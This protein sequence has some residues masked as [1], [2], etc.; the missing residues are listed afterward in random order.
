MCLQ[1]TPQVLTL[2]TV[3]VFTINSIPIPMRLTTVS[4]QNKD[5]T[6]NKNPTNMKSVG[7]SPQ[8]LR[9]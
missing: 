2:I 9:L 8:H 7:L 5:H 6:T 1:V 3:I 4:D